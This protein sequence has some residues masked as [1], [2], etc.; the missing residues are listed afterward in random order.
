MYLFKLTFKDHIPAWPKHYFRNN[1]AWKEFKYNNE[2][3]LIVHTNLS[4]PEIESMFP[5]IYSIQYMSLR[6]GKTANPS[7]LSRR[8]KRNKTAPAKFVPV[9]KER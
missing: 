6:P 1:I 8:M 2:Q 9:T 7:P 5:E 3:S 4:A